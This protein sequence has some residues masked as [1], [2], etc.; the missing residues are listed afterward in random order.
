ME[1]QTLIH[2]PLGLI[3][4][5]LAVPAIIFTLNTTAL[6]ARVF[7]V[8][9]ALVFAYFVPTALSF[10]D[11]IPTSAPIYKQVKLIILPASLFL[12]TISVDLKSILK[13]GPKALLLFFSATVGVMAGGPI[14]LWL[15]KDKLPPDIWK[16]M[17]AL[18]GSWIGGGANF[19]AVGDAVGASETMIGMMVVVDV[20]I[21][22]LWTGLLMYFAGRY[23]EIDKKLGADN[24]SIETLKEKIIHF[25][26]QVGRIG[27]TKDYM[28]ILGMT[29]VAV[30]VATQ[31]GNALPELGAVVSHGTWRVVLITTFALIISFTPLRKLEGVGASK[32]GTVFLYMLIGVIGAGADLAEM[33]KYPWLVAMGA[34]WMLIHMFVVLLVMKLSK[35]PLFFMAVGSQ[36]NIGAAASAPVVASAF[37]PALATVG[38]LLGVLGYVVGTY[39]ALMC[40]ALLQWVS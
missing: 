33:V 1:P 36:A 3:A 34:V 31:L 35:A 13:L 23:L 26:K 19:I 2:D 18:A 12:L 5:L 15:F 30:W 32:L 39:A 22:S 24:S 16:G 21:A 17:S 10:F 4:V 20:V 25:Q 29:F 28:V 8:V 37:H 6:G 40:A 38:V 7:K 27:S 9:P 11:I 14:S